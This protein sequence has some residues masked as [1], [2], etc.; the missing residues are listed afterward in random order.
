MKMRLHECKQV[1]QSSSSLLLATL[2]KV[3]NRLTFG[4]IS[5]TAFVLLFFIRIQR[6][7]PN[8]LYGNCYVHV[9]P[10]VI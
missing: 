6:H 9:M 5:E 1:L 7:P 10:Y 3:V 4:N 8:M 2:G